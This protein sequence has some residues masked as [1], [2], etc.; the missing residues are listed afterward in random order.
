MAEKKDLKKALDE[1]L[2]SE[3]TEDELQAIELYR[4][5]AGWEQTNLPGTGFISKVSILPWLPK[6][7]E[8]HHLIDV[9]STTRTASD[10]KSKFLLSN[11]ICPK[12]GGFDHPINFV[13]T[14]QH[15]KRVFWNSSFG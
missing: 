10:G 15:P 8:R 6:R 11:F 1:I 9:S 7:C 4:K 14:P 12:L 13:A 5:V 3:L 2:G